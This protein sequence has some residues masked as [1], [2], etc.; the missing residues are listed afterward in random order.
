MR[1]LRTILA[2]TLPMLALIACADAR[3]GSSERSREPDASL[4][5]RNMNAYMRP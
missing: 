5:P 2:L 3:S 4:Q 1:R